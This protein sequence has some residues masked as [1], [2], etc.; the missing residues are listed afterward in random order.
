MFVYVSG[1]TGG[2]LVSLPTHKAPNL[3]SVDHPT[4]SDAV[5][6]VFLKPLEL[7][8]KLVVSTWSLSQFRRAPKARA[9]AVSTVPCFKAKTIK[10]IPLA[11]ESEALTLAYL[12]LNLIDLC[13][14]LIN[15]C[16]NLV[17]V[18]PNLVY[19]CPCLVYVCLKWVYLWLNLI[20]PCLHLV[21][22]WLNNT[23]KRGSS[24]RDLGSFSHPRETTS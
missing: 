8:L 23:R 21:G 17:Y 22:I 14:I 9:W 3:P 16:D 2:E 13:L 12:C 11:L 6:F 15:L 19:L 18:C 20:Y 5:S 4:C 10:S 7:K 1:C 24:S